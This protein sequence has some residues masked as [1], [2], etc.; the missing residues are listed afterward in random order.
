MQ[1][2]KSESTAANG[3]SVSIP[4]SDIKFVPSGM[5]NAAGEVMVGAAFGD[6]TTGAHGTF[7]R[8]PAATS[9][10]NTLTQKTIMP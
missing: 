9:R 8:Y 2:N 4:A 7:V 5:K 3:K 6:M 1:T 10:S